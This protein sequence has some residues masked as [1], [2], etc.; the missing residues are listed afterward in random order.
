MKLRK[1]RT[2]RILKREIYDFTD[3]SFTEKKVGTDLQFSCESAEE[4]QD[5][6]DAE[7]NPQ[8]KSNRD[9]GENIDRLQ[10]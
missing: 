8:R 4:T 7:E 3:M 2:K 1:N 9:M 10:P 5:S 6:G